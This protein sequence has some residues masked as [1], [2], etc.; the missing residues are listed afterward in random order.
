LIPHTPYKATTPNRGNGGVVLFNGRRSR[1]WRRLSHSDQRVAHQTHLGAE[2][3]LNYRERCQ[4]ALGAL[5]LL[6]RKCQ[7]R[8]AQI[9]QERAALLTALQ[10]A[11][12]L[13]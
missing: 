1:T 5:T 4:V 13:P 6:E 3:P 7:L 2:S 8:L 9:R 10:S 12:A 11:R